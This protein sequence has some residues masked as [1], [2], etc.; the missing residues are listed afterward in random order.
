MFKLFRKI[1]LNHDIT[2]HDSELLEKYNIDEKIAVQ[3][4][5]K[6]EILA[7]GKKKFIKSI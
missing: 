2:K 1:N 6:E 7:E 5:E 4:M 3:L